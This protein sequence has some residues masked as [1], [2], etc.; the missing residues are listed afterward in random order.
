MPPPHPNPTPP[1]RSLPSQREWCW[2]KP[3]LSQPWQPSG[4]GPAPAGRQ[5][6][7]LLLGQVW[8]SWRA[9][10]RAGL[11]LR[12]TAMPHCHCRAAGWWDCCWRDGQWSLSVAKVCGCGCGCVCVWGGG[13]GLLGW[14]CC[15]SFLAVVGVGVLGHTATSA[16]WDTILREGWGGGVAGVGHVGC[17]V[18]GLLLEGWAVEPVSGQGVCRY[19][20]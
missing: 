11:S 10:W 20:A 6:T 15:L 1:H 16:P 2:I 17:R 3:V 14:G 5:W 9:S 12:A 4:P 7:S 19:C 13:L 8:A 18:V